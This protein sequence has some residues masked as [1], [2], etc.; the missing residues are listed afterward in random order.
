MLLKSAVIAGRPSKTTQITYPAKLLM[1]AIKDHEFDVI[2][3]L[4]SDRSKSPLV[5]TVK[6]KLTQIGKRLVGDFTFDQRF[7]DELYNPL[8]KRG[9]KFTFTPV[10]LGNIEKGS[11]PTS[12][13]VGVCA[14]MYRIPE[15]DENGR[16]GVIVD[17]TEKLNDLKK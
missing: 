10:F 16:K 9:Y 5:G 11:T 15:R 17:E 12:L 8:A 4:S 13:E 6:L 7:I 3:G 2:L 1:K 14:I